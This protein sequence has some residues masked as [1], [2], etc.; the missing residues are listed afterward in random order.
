MASARVMPFQFRSRGRKAVAAQGWP[1]GGSPP[2]LPVAKDNLADTRRRIAEGLE[3]DLL[4]LSGGVSAGKYDLVET[5]LAE[6][7]AEFFFTRGRMQPGQPL[8][9][10]QARGRYFFGLPGNPA[11]TMVTFAAVARVAVA[12]LGGE[13]EGEGVR[14]MG[15][16]QGEMRLKPGL[17]RFLPAEMRGPGV[18]PVRYSGSGDVP[19]LARA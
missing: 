6:Y 7:G 3:Q 18:F 13:T 10:G 19:A 16:L 1:A 4:L 8:V 2:V 12:R 9:F 15:T 5:V 11:S 14:G 17:T